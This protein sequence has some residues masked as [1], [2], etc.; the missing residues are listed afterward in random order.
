MMV[1][2]VE[3]SGMILAA[4]G[5]R[6]SVF[7]HFVVDGGPITWFVLIPLSVISIALIM[8]YLITIRRGTQTPPGLMKA[9]VAAARHGQLRNIQE[10]ASED[11]SMLGQ[12]AY[13]AAANLP[14]GREAALA[15]VDEA[16][17]EQSGKLMRR[18]EYLNVVGNISPMIG[19]L[20]TVVGMIQAFNRIYA[21]GGSVPDASQ[22]V[23]D[24]AIALVNTFWGL[25]IAIPGLTAYAF[26]RNRIDAFAAECFR[27]CDGIVGTAGAEQGTGAPAAEPAG[28]HGG[29]R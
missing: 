17:E 12:S 19:L 4:D 9:I 28:P 15:A 6:S 2:S 3:Y 7:K 16:V 10:I 14:A 26:F 1:C 22:L 27:L 18:I 29:I 25:F 5:A 13:A 8:H 20:G 23:G 21:A 11:D 24:I